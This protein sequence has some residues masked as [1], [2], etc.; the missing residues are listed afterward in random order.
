[1]DLTSGFTAGAGA[2]WTGGVAGCEAA[3]SRRSLSAL[4]LRA[5]SPREG[6]WSCANSN[7]L[8]AKITELRIKIAL[9]MQRSINAGGFSAEITGVTN[10]LPG[11]VLWAPLWRSF[12]C[13]E[14]SKWF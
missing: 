6:A 8:A 14:N 7:G 1:M 2:G 5:I 11:W 4:I 10:A 3:A 13:L 9:R 12:F